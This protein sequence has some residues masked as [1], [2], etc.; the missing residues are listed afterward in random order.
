MNCEVAKPAIPEISP[1][2]Q[3]VANLFRSSA[4]GDVLPYEMVNAAAGC[5]VRANRHIVATARNRVLMDDQVHIA[6][7]SKVGYKRLSPVEAADTL[8]CDLERSRNAARK[9]VKKAKRI[10]VLDLPADKRNE[11]VGRASLCAMITEGTSTKSQEKLMAA[12][13]QQPESTAILAMKQTLEA[14]KSGK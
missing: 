10:S 8:G 2:A 5:D 7:V 4:V 9:G 12:A 14:L 1:A 11:F 3:R 6:T 13:S